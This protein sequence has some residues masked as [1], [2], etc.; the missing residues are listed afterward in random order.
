MRDCSRE[1]SPQGRCPYPC[2]S[3]GL[4]LGGRSRAAAREALCC[5]HTGSRRDSAWRLL[6]RAGTGLWC[7]STEPGGSAQRWGT[8]GSHRSPREQTASCPRAARPPPCLRAVP[9]SPSHSIITSASRLHMQAACM[10]SPLHSP[11]LA[12]TS[13]P[14]ALAPAASHLGTSWGPL[15]GLSEEGGVL[16][17]AGAAGPFPGLLLRLGLCPLTG[18]GVFALRPHEMGSGRYPFLCNG[19]H[20]ALPG[21]WT[22]RQLLPSCGVGA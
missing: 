7:Q 6:C 11:A 13:L 15:P 19:Q 5:S 2:P 9:A 3:I 10:A 18:G 12:D 1:H 22:R 8:A 17:G 14:H 4:T 20:R 16:A 21:H